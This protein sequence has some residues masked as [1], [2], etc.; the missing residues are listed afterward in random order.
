MRRKL[1]LAPLIVNRSASPDSCPSQEHPNAVARL[2]LQYNFQ[3][4]FFRLFPYLALMSFDAVC[5]QFIPFC[6]KANDLF[7]LRDTSPSSNPPFLDTA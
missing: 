3:M 2:N 7:L 6:C 5:I 1:Q 4:F